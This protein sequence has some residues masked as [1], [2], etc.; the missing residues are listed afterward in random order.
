MEKREA[1]LKRRE[2]GHK[3]KYAR[4]LMGF[5]Q[6]F[7]AKELG[8]K[9]QAVISLESGRRGIDSFEYFK[10]VELL[11]VSPLDKDTQ[12]E[13]LETYK[14]YI[15]AEIREQAV[16]KTLMQFKKICDDYDFLKNI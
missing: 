3:F 15:A 14:K 9:R 13:S 6:E 12:A 4:E 8:I 2:M 1:E 10:L 5:T 16:K 7:I 11:G